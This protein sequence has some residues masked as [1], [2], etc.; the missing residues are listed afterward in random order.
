MNQSEL[1][2]ITSNRHQA[3][4]NA[5]EQVAIGYSFT[6]DWWRKWRENFEP[7]TDRSKAKPKQMQ[8]TALIVN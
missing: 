5:C 4:E 6:S 8:I 3:R 1:K 7:I 2:A